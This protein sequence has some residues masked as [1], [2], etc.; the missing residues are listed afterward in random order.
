MVYAKVYPRSLRKQARIRAT[1][2]LF[3]Q[4]FNAGLQLMI[5]DSARLRAEYQQIFEY[6]GLPIPADLSDKENISAKL[7]HAQ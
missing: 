7:L 6:R 4:K 2:C 5:G 3:Y 1:C